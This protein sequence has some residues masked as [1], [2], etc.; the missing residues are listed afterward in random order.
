[1]VVETDGLMGMESP[2]VLRIHLG[3]GP[4]ELMAGATIDACL[5]LLAGSDLTI[6]DLDGPPPERHPR[7]H[8]TVILVRALRRRLVHRCNLAVA[9]QP[10]HADL[11][12]FLAN[13]RVDVVASLPGR[14]S[15]DWSTLGLL[16]TLRRFNAAGYGLAGGGLT[17]DLVIPS[18][19]DH[20]DAAIGNILGSHGIRFNGLHLVSP[21]APRPGGLVADLQRLAGVVH[22]GRVLGVPCRSALSVDWDGAVS[23]D[24]MPLNRNV[25]ELVSLSG[26]MAPVTSM[27]GLESAPA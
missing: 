11:P 2:E 16:Q 5:A 10:E 27:S 18:A 9:S 22:P 7:F 6:V 1:V 15:H 26:L 24:S 12:E 23:D 19:G 20:T 3:R 4:G 25:H 17:L 8:E 14:P 13:H 21:L